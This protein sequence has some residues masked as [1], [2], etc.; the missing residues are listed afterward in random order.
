MLK[1]YLKKAPT[2]IVIG[3]TGF[4]AW[5]ALFPEGNLSPSK[6]SPTPPATANGSPSI[7]GASDRDPFLVVRPPVSKAILAT[8]SATPALGPETKVAKS[9]SPSEIPADED[10]VLGGM[11]LGGTFIDGREQIAI[12]DNKVYARGESLRRADGSALPYVV[13]AVR[14]DH[15]VLR[16]GDRDFVLGFSNV[17]R[18]ASPKAEAPALAKSE[19]PAAKGPPTPK[20]ESLAQRKEAPRSRRPERDAGNPASMLLQLLSGAVGGTGAGEGGASP[21][22]GLAGLGNAAGANT[23]SPG[24]AVNP[25]TIQAGL[26]ALMGK[27]DNIGREGATGGATP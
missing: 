25:T 15:A 26:D 21:A 16:R 5:P 18:S 8:T 22:S 11:R 3:V 6:V 13:S 20:V 7:A 23:G 2:L 19:P 24:I 14:K 12:I 4:A 10:K 1:R 27:S 17:P 9:A